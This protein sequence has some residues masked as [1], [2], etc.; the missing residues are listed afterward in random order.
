MSTAVDFAA[1]LIDPVAIKAAGHSGVIAYVSPPRP[2]AEW[3]LAKPVT[4]DYTDQCRAAGIDVASVWQYG[5]PGNP[6]A[7]SDWTTGYEGGRRMAQEAADRHRAA[8]GPDKAPIFFAV[9]EDINLDSWNVLAVHF[10][11]G[12]NSIL[13]VERTGIYGHARVCAWAAEDGVIGTAPGGKF[14]AWQTRAWSGALIGPEAV[15]YQRVID[16]PSNPGPQIDG[17][18]VDVNDILAPVY[19]QWAHFTQPTLPPEGPAV[20]HPPMVEEDQTGDSPNSHSRNGTRV[21][22]GVIHTQEGNGT[23]QSLT[24]Y[25]KRPSS[26][27]SY[28]YVVDNERCIAVVDTDR[29]SWSVLDAN[30]YTVNLCFAGSRASMTREEWL[31]NFGR[32]ID[33]AA[34]LMVRD[35][36][37]Y[38]FEPRIIGWEELGAGRD[39]FTD[40]AG[41]TY[42]LGIGTHTDCGPNFPWDVYNERVQH[43]AAANVAPPANAINAKAAETPWLGARLTDGENTCPDGVGKWAHFEHGYVYWH[44]ATGAHPISDPVFDKFAELGWEAGA[45]GY[46]ANDH[47]VLKDPAGAEWGVVQGFQGGAVY[48]KHGQP[49]FWVHGAIRDHWNRSGFENGPYGWPVSDEQPFDGTAY[50]DFEAGR[51]F[52]T[53][54]PTLGLLAAGDLDTPLADAA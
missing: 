17:T 20:L 49:A 19:G 15:L 36:R 22:L 12:V 54:K 6:S 51:I 31:T 39:G 26:G 40:H 1:R 32:G 13:G 29:C 45:L 21:R 47:T 42:G 52:W 34:W 50:Q 53:P 16:T 35:A 28:H 48:R 46:P 14:W 33:M 9:D 37:H 43:W 27:V 11:R 3:M 18:A 8:G 38:G 7:P 41:I 25:L 2:G 44:P 30:P 5:K 4:K 23:A 10:F 24:D